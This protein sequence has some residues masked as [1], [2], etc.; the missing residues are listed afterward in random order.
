[1]EI[2]LSLDRIEGEVAVCYDGDGNKYEIPA[3]GLSECMIISAVFDENGNFI[4]ACPLRDETE[5]VKKELSARTKALFKRNK[6]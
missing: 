1:M 2:K 6:K 3:S 5:T 4:S